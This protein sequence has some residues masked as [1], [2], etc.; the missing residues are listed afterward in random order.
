MHEG[1]ILQEA[2]RPVVITSTICTDTPSWKEKNMEDDLGIQLRKFGRRGQQDNW[3]G[4][5]PKL[6]L[7]V[8]GDSKGHA[9]AKI[10]EK[11]IE[12]LKEWIRDLEAQTETEATMNQI[13]R[14][15]VEPELWDD[16]VDQEEKRQA[17][18]KW[19]DIEGFSRYQMN[20]LGQV[21]T[22][23]SGLMVERNASVAVSSKEFS[24]VTLRHDAGQDI[25][26]TIRDIQ[27]LVAGVA[28]TKDAVKG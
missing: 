27:M 19:Y 21:L 9:L 13:E 6:N 4:Y 22:K 17:K 2:L 1:K 23:V 3:E 14:G 12:K 15:M 20:T 28:D 8:R 26:L 16:E 10:K 11:A 25:I 18:Y 24:T 5:C 7:T